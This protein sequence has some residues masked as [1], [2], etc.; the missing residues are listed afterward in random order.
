[1]IP[2]QKSLLKANL[3]AV[4]LGLAAM[5]LIVS[6]S[7]ILNHQ[8]RENERQRAISDAR[9]L[10]FGFSR[11][12][13]EH[14]WRFREEFIFSLT[15]LPYERF[16]IDVDNTPETL[17]TARRFLSINQDILAEL[18]VAGPDGMGRTIR[19]RS[20]NYVF[21][22]PLQP[23]K[24]R[25]KNVAGQDDIVAIDGIVQAPDGSTRATVSA[26]LDPV[27]FWRDSLTS[28]S[29]S[30]PSLWVHLL[31]SQGRPLVGR[32]GALTLTD[33]P[34]FSPEVAARLTEDARDGFEGRFFHRI[35]QQGRKVDFISAYVPL[36]IESWS[37]LLLVSADESVVLGPAAKAIGTLTIITTVVF[38]LLF[39][40][41]IHFIRVT[42]RTHSQLE[43]SRREAETAA[44]EAEAANRA[45]SA[46][47]AMM[48]HELRTPLNSIMGL[49]ESLLERLHG[50]LTEKQ[51][52]YVEMVLTSGR[53]LLNLINDILDLAKI[54]SGRFQ[55][56]FAQCELRTLCEDS[57]AVIQPMVSRRRQVL[58]SDFSA[59]RD[60]KV[61]ADARLLLQ[62][63][64][65]L[66]GNAVKFTPEGGT[67]GLRLI[68]ES[69]ESVVIQVWDQGIGISPEDQARLF[70]PFVQLDT[71]LARNYE[72]TGLGLALVKQI[73]LLHG[74]DASV[75]S[76]PGE[77]SVFSVRLP[78]TADQAVPAD[79][80]AVLPALALE[81]AQT[82]AP[83]V[84][85]PHILLVDDITFNVIPVRD[86][87]EKKGCR[88]TVAENG[89]LAVEKA[90]QVRPD[91]ILMDI[92]MPE[93]DGLEATRLIRA[94]PDPVI[95]RVPI[96]A[97]TAM[98]MSTDR[99]RCEEAGMDDF[100]AKPYS[101]HDLY[102]RIQARLADPVSLSPV[103]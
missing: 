53:H 81:A 98:A 51:A 17:V 68:A 21:F 100:I 82:A 75:A 28:F 32:H 83:G 40:F 10:A 91:L 78:I 80:P 58:E 26:V 13:T 66:L 102:V 74:G 99:K 62:L 72:G 6:G 47:L 73:A 89:R 39:A 95:S 69:R 65:N 61:K 30:H 24:A 25:A 4:F 14:Y 88:V 31:D 18:V 59:V 52:R 2:L 35:E 38:L 103:G 50:P 48:S 37:G 44:S 97:V 8:L 12:A 55:A 60:L 71:R 63:M 85:G 93:M 9:Q 1:L 5:V 22:S 7:L 27:H 76:R 3:P 86:Y 42:L 64:V 54:E 45:K 77:G 70:Q 84:S 56:N 46:F 79:A 19:M 15:H 57:L 87:L 16:L 34:Q 101:P 41:F 90:R 29:S 94:F 43:M 92:Q 96:F 11:E 49:S 33:Q 23:I 20:E 36:R 67:L